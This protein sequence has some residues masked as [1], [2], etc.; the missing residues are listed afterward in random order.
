MKKFSL[1]VFTFFAL[2]FFAASV[3]AQDPIWTEDFDGGLPDDW[4]AIEVAGDNSD[5]SNWVWTDVGATGTTAGA[6]PPLASATAANGWM[7]FDSDANCTHEVQDAWLMSPKL[8]MSANAVVRVE[9]SQMYRRFNDVTLMMVSSDSINWTEI[10]L[11][12]NLTAN[13]YSDGSSNAASNPHIQSVNIS[14]VAANQP[15]VWFAF[16]FLSDA[17]T[18]DG[19]T[20]GFG[21][22]YS[23]QV[24]DVAIYDWDDAP[25]IVFGD[26]IFYPPLSYSTPVSQIKTDTFGFFADISNTGT[27]AQMNVEMKV[28]VV[29]DGDGSVLFTGSTVLDELPAGTADSTV[30]IDGSFAPEL[31]V[32]TYS[33]NYSVVTQE[34]PSDLDATNSASLPF[35]VTENVWAKEPA[36]TIVTRPGGEP[37]DWA[38]GNVYKTSSDWVEEYQANSVEWFSQVVDGTLEGVR[39]SIILAEVKEDEVLPNWA[40]FDTDISFITNPGLTL[41]AFHDFEFTTTDQGTFQTLALED[42][43]E[44]T[45]SVVLKPGNRYILI[46]SY[47]GDYKE[48]LHGFNDEL[49][50]QQTWSTVLYTDQWYN[51]GFGTDLTAVLRMSIGLKG[52]TDVKG[53]TLPDESLT[54]YPN[55]VNDKLNVEL[56]FEKPELANV[57]IAEL[58]GKVIKIDILKNAV[59]ETRQ[60]DVSGL[61]AGT[62]LIRVATEEGSKTKK[63]VVVR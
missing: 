52:V 22:A 56:S 55:P 13:D 23:W 2:L 34:S 30:F 46:A 12:P 63:F 45:T 38:I 33:I 25:T 47:E 59:N 42:F 17:T 3:S 49:D 24:D 60:Y 36:P 39:V 32:G 10:P 41:R 43:N 14:S 44:G 18:I 1:K 50:T 27:E 16:R 11:G 40:D 31:E 8:D 15:E 54:F 48:T 19:G 5:N 7:I 61:A 29:D 9:F 53:R 62:Y 28:E 58:S 26:F 20:G 57:T 35:E 37:V 21:C 4:T 51:A 6:T